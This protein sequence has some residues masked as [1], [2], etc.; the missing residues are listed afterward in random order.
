[1]KRN[2]VIAAFV[3]IL[4]STLN[5]GQI[6][7]ARA[8]G[9]DGCTLA[10]VA[11]A[12]GFSYSGV[13]ILPSGQV[14]VAAVGIFRSD[15][16]GNVTGSESNSL[17]GNST[18]QTLLGKITVNHDCS[19]SLFAKVYEGGVLARTSY[20]HLQYQNNT[21]ELLGIFQKLVLPNGSS[22]PVV[23]TIAGKRLFQ[24]HGE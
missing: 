21:N 17:G 6:P 15:A 18:D 19:G 23:I 16:A 8:W 5:A 13:G 3:A 9:S 2:L 12:F 1:M 22:L 24:G 20:I 7:A 11:G 10:N 14:P 4:F